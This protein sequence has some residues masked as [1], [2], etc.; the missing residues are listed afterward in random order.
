MG[1]V[2]AAGIV[3]SAGRGLDERKVRGR[4]KDARIEDAG[5]FGGHPP[6]DQ[7]RGQRGHSRRDGGRLKRE[8]EVLRRKQGF[9]AEAGGECLQLADFLLHGLRH[10]QPAEPVD[11]LRRIGFPDGVI[12]PP[13]ALDHSRALQL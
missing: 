8:W 12:L 4:G 11:D 9:P 2:E 10:I 1:G 7:G 5:N 3:I 6:L 13:D